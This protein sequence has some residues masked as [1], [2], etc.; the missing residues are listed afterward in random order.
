MT[1]RRKIHL[2]IGHGKTGSSAIQTVLA[3]NHER[4]RQRGILYPHHV[5]FEQAKAGIAT[6][7][8]LDREDWFDGQVMRIARDSPGWSTLLFSNEHIFARCDEFFDNVG[9]YGDDFEFEIILFVRHPLE[10]LRSGYQQA[11]KRGGF[12]GSIGAFL[13]HSDA[14]PRASALIDRCVE[15]GIG[16]KLFNYSAIRRN[17]IEHFFAHLG[18]WEEMGDALAGEVGT[19]NRSLTLGELRFVLALNQIFG[20]EYGRR[21]SDALVNRLP[22]LAADQIPVDDAT[23][24]ALYARDAAAIHS[25]NRH[26]PAAE[27]I[28]LEGGA[29]E[30][31][32]PVSEGLTREQGDIVRDVFPAA[33]A[34]A[35]GIVLRDIA[36]KYETGEAL[37][38]DEAIALMGYAQKARPGGRIIAG[39]LERWRQS[40]PNPATASDGDES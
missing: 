4:L 8:N 37:T 15:H 21:V 9:R 35:D 31:P 14:A 33:L 32:G 1:V 40:A 16:F 28:D 5:S 23:K 20:P 22:D 36:M 19:I 29:P 39:Q 27:R 26:L 12:T 18:L 17:V 11:V 25:I 3:N 13:P 38:R 2:H 6:S 24:H 7:G 30:E 34:P 10:M